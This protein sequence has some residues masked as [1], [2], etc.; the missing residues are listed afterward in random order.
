MNRVVLIANTSR[1]KVRVAGDRSGMPFTISSHMCR[2][3]A[4]NR[5]AQCARAGPLAS[6]SASAVSAMSVVLLRPSNL[7]P[8]PLRH[9]FSTPSSTTRA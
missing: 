1:I 9:H 8:K 2:S 7:R 6:S 4:L 3:S 5:V